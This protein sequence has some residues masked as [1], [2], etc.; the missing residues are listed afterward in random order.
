MQ[1]TL[2]D[3]VECARTKLNFSAGAQRA[4]FQDGVAVKVITGKRQ[5]NMKHGGRERCGWF[6][7]VGHAFFPERGYCIARH[8]IV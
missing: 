4:F 8:Y 3:S 5:Q 6:R 2:D 1:Q 7:S